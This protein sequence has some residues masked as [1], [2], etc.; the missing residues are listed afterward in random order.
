MPFP[1]LELP[2]ELRDHIYSFVAQEL[3]ATVHAGGSAKLIC[4]ASITF[5]NKQL[6]SEFMSVLCLDADT[7]IANVLN[8]DFRHMV[9]FYNHLSTLEHRSLV[10]KP[11]GAEKRQIKVR[12]E[13]SDAISQFEAEDL[14]N[15][16]VKRSAL[17]TKKGAKVECSYEV[18]DPDW[19]FS[20]DI[21]REYWLKRQLYN[22]FSGIAEGA[23]KEAIHEVLA[24]LFNSPQWSRGHHLMAYLDY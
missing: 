1:F 10:G 20:W 17:S 11:N 14:L 22:Q 6:R 19:R 9:T 16:W 7:I 8:F 21:R 24:P 15:R 18:A 23:Q 13:F 3:T 12:L 4:P 2:Q 5:V